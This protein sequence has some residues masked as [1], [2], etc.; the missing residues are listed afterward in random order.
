LTVSRTQ[1][2]IQFYGGGGNWI[3]G[4]TTKT[5]NKSEMSSNK[6]QNP[7]YKTLLEETQKL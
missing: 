2:Q 1:K 4:I 5:E 3:V 6:I 7:A